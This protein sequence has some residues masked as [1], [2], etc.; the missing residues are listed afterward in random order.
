[1]KLRCER[2]YHYFLTASC[3]PGVALL[4]QAAMDCQE[5]QIDSSLRHCRGSEN[6]CCL[7]ISCPRNNDENETHTSCVENDNYHPDDISKHTQPITS[8]AAAPPIET[9]QNDN[10][11]RATRLRRRPFFKV[12]QNSYALHHHFLLVILL[13]LNTLTPTQQQGITFGGILNLDKCYAAMQ[14]SQTDDKISRFQYVSFV[15]ELADNQFK[16][17]GYDAETNTYGNVPTEDFNSLP[18]A[19]RHTFNFFACGG[20][21]NI[22]ENAFLY[23]EGTAPGDPV[24]APQ[25]EVYLY[26]V[27]ERV[28]SAIEDTVPKTE[29]PTGSPTTGSPTTAPTP[30]EMVV[31]EK[32]S[33]NYQISVPSFITAGG[34]QNGD[35]DESEELKEALLTAVQTWAQNMA[36]DLSQEGGGSVFARGNQRKKKQ[37]KHGRVLAVTIDPDQ[38]QFTNVTNAGEGFQSSVLFLFFCICSFP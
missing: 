32:V 19:V 7:S 33:L 21:N 38:I 37:K 26:Q 22:C 3:C 13:F 10:H 9:C 20:P 30:P 29:K 2:Y 25:Q 14:N 12:T 17:F 24:P 4:H 15:Q 36:S 31:E 8:T 34:F 35:T 18:E 6:S 5:C 27:C 23:T 1:M 28:E 11:R 16:S